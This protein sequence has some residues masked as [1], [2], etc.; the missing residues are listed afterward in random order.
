MQKKTWKKKTYGPNDASGV[1]WA[2][3]RSRSGARG[4]H[5]A[6]DKSSRAP[7]LSSSSRRRRC[8]GL[9]WLLLMRKESTI[10][11]KSTKSHVKLC[12]TSNELV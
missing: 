3:S 6:R 8:H 10:A 7:L 4:D 9:S 2:R 11:R 5:G 12:R 1:V